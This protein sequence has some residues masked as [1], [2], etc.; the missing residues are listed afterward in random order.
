MAR[1]IFVCRHCGGRLSFQSAE[2]RDGRAIY[3]CDR[4]NIKYEIERTRE[5]RIRGDK[6]EVVAARKLHDEKKVESK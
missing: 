2:Y 4:C 3:T 1:D 6:W 5:S